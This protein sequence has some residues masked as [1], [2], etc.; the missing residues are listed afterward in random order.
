ML[1]NV[2]RC[3]K[4]QNYFIVHDVHLINRIPSHPFGC[5]ANVYTLARNRIK[6]EDR[7]GKRI[8]IGYEKNMKGYRVYSLK[9]A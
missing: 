1:L 3:L 2:A 9:T 7:A 5:L 6:F 4:S 8:V